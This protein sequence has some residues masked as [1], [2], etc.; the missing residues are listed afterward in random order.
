[1]SRGSCSLLRHFSLSAE[2]FLSY[3]FS[4]KVLR[5]SSMK[6]HFSEYSVGI[7]ECTVISL[8]CIYKSAFIFIL[9]VHW[10]VTSYR[11]GRWEWVCYSAIMHMLKCV[12]LHVQAPCQTTSLTILGKPEKKCKIPPSGW[13]LLCCLSSHNC[14]LHMDIQ[15]QKQ[16]PQ[17]VC[18]SHT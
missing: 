13:I 16:M 6:L 12:E 17:M 15:I 18:C 5:E 2:C 14:F 3:L 8:Y 7:P 4:Y 11:L 10:K 1:M 9:F